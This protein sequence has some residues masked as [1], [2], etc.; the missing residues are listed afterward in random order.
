ME[1]KMNKMMNKFLQPKVTFRNRSLWEKLYGE[2][3]HPPCVGNHFV[4]QKYSRFH[5]SIGKWK[6]KATKFYSVRK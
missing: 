3:S 6:K 4:P 5:C 2:D 1:I